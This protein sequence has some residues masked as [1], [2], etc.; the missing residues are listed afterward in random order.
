MRMQPA[1][2]ASAV[3]GTPVAVVISADKVCEL[4]PHTLR[5]ERQIAGGAEQGRKQIRLERAKQ[6][7]AIRHRQ[8]TATPISCWPGVRA[9][10]FRADPQTHTVEV[11]DRTAAC[12]HGMNLQQ[13]RAQSH[14]GNFRVEHAL[15]L[16]GVV[17]DVG[18]G[19]PHIEADDPIESRG[20]RGPRCPDDATRRA[21]Q[22]RVLAMELLC[23]DQPAGR[24]HELQL[25]TGQFRCDLIHVSPQYGRKIRIDNGRVATGHE[26]HQRTHFVRCRNLRESHLARQLHQQSLVHRIA[27]AMHE[28]DGATVDALLQPSEQLAPH[29][30]RVGDLQ[31]VS[32]CTYPLI[33]LDD[34]FVEHRRQFDV[35]HEKLWTMLVA[36]SQR[37]CESFCNQQQRAIALAL[38]QRVRRHRRTHPDDVDALDRERL[39]GSDIENVANALDGR[40]AIALWVIRQEFACDETG[41]R[42]CGRRRR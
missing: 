33:N 31:N 26:L 39:A 13:R 41:R 35:T 11:T 5:V 42:V 27:I 7:V 36:N 14:T 20:G 38:Q 4:S 37:I 3:C 28:N 10:R 19:T 8:R 21:R 32:V 34:L 40:I 16:A 1:A 15:V 17:S 23:I 25:H 24:L 22:D 18:R 6:H 9:S 12:R 29:F 30:I 2:I